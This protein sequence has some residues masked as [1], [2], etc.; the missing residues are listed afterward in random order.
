[1]SPNDVFIMNVGNNFEKFEKGIKNYKR[2]MYGNYLVCKCTELNLKHL[3]NYRNTNITIS[4][5]KNVQEC[6]IFFCF[7][8]PYAAGG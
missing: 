1:M 7:I 5:M 2:L 8:N 4:M 6:N 3:N